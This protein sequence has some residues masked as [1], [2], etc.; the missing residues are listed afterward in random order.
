MTV[1]KHPEDVFAPDSQRQIGTRKEKERSDRPSSV[2]SS[3]G[4]DGSDVH[5]PRR[6]AEAAHRDNHDSL[7]TTA[8]QE[9]VAQTGGPQPR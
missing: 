7:E 8:C 5:R 2:D 9:R 4:I 6:I 1:R 3:P